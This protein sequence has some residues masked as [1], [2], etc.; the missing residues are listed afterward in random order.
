MPHSHQLPVVLWPAYA[1]APIG[2]AAAGVLDG[3]SENQSG[4]VSM[5]R[6]ANIISFVFK[7]GPPLSGSLTGTAIR[8]ADF[9]N[10]LLKV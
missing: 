4:S 1:I 8:Y 5:H 2:A 6:V 7:I 10:Y 3:E 9:T